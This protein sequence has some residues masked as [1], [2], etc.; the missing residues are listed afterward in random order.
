MSGSTMF[1]EL[2][3]GF[4]FLSLREMKHVDEDD[5]RALV[6]LNWQYR[7]LVELNWQYRA[8]VELNWQWKTDLRA[9]K[10]LFHCQCVHNRTHMDWPGVEPRPLWW[11]A[12][13]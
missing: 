12:G 13:D 6:E 1:F 8:L 11:K 9:K 2:F 3:P 7:A 4:A 10:R 5:Y